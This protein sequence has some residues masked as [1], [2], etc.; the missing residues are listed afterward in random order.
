M[1]HAIASVSSAQRPAACRRLRSW[2]RVSGQGPDPTDDRPQIEDLLRRRLPRLEGHALRELEQHAG[3]HAVGLRAQ[4]QRA[5]EV[6]RRGR[7]HHHDLDP[8]RPMQRQRQVEVVDARS[9]RDTPARDALPRRVSSR[10]SRSWPSTSLASVSAL[11]PPLDRHR[12]LVRADIDPDTPRP[13][14]ASPRV[15]LLPGSP[16]LHRRLPLLWMQAL[17]PRILHGMGEEG[18]GPI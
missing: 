7:V 1:S 4:Q 5:P 2:V 13:D 11:G 17:G 18:G 12:D 3:I 6:P 8:S 15:T 9:P 10:T 16:T 14:H